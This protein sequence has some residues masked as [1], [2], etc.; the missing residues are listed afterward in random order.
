MCTIVW[1]WEYHVAQFDF[2]QLALFW[3]WEDGILSMALDR[4]IDLLLFDL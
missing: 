2:H 1:S 3:Q 4:S